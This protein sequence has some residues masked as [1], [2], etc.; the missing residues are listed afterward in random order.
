MSVELDRG[1]WGAAVVPENWCWASF[2]EFWVDH[3]DA[4]R[5][6]P[7][8]LYAQEGSLLVVDQGASLVGGYTDD[9]S[10]QSLAPLPAI[11]FGDHTRV[12]KYVDRPFVQGAEGVRVLCARCPIEPRFAYHALRCVRLPDKGY[13]RHFKFLKATPFPLAPFAEQRRIVAKIETLSAKS[14]R[15]RDQLDRVARLVEKYK[16]A[17]LTAAFRGGLTSEWRVKNAEI[18]W[19]WT[20]VSLSDIASVGTGSTPKRGN[21]KYYSN[22]EIAWVTSGAVNAPVVLSADEYITDAAL[23]ETNCKVFPAGT[24]LMAMYGEGQTR[25]RVAVLGID[26]ATNQAL[27]AIQVKADGPAT[28]DFVRW[29]LR[30]GYMHLREQAAGGVQPNLNLGIVKAWRLPLPSRLE[31][32]EITRRIE[33]AL[34]WVDRLALEAGN[35]RKL[36]EHL[37]R[38]VLSKAFAGK[39]VP[40]QLNDEPAAVL[41]ERIK[42][43]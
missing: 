30:S 21:P 33:I 17:I 7:Q 13:S 15:A 18:H 14:E 5:K 43:K 40:Q 29:H 36:I 2:D 23:R 16:R 24:I 31:Q 4:K 27:A 8:N 35:A 42:A 11:V 39:L 3:T 1:D 32:Q 28:S 19:P 25:G 10:K 9:V 12:V 41:L 20:E 6:I 37:D 22:G 34:N 26:A 38:A